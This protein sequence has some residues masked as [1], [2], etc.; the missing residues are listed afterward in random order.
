M[1]IMS[2]CPA[3]CHP[4]P[5]ERLG[6]GSGTDRWNLPSLSYTSRVEADGN[7][8]RLLSTTG[9]RSTP[10]LV[11]TGVMNASAPLARFTEYETR[12]RVYA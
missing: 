11:L 2:S 7:T 1:T 12:L 5:G 4:T 3:C 9:G 8:T 10:P 6:Y